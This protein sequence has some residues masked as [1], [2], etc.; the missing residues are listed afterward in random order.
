MIL[1]HFFLP[2]VSFSEDSKPSNNWPFWVK[3]EVCLPPH[4][5]LFRELVIFSDCVEKTQFFCTFQSFEMSFPNG[6][7]PIFNWSLVKKYVIFV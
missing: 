6:F 4:P 2:N 3:M 1:C 7:G 5:Q